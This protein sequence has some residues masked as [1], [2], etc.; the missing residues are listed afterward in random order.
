MFSRTKIVEFDL[1]NYATKA[2]L[3]SE[4]GVD[5][6]IFFKKRDLASL[7]SGVDKLDM[8]R[9]KNVPTNLGNF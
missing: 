1:S 2:D 4:A 9:L 7:A 3:K 6:S 8:D 5:A